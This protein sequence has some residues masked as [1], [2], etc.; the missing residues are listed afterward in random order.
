MNLI[1][2]MIPTYKTLQI[3]GTSQDIIIS[4]NQSSFNNSVKSRFE[5]Y[6]GSIKTE[7]N[8]DFESTC[9][10]AGT[11]QSEMNKSL[12][13]MEFPNARIENDEKIEIQMN[14]ATAQVKAVNSSWSLNGYKGATDGS[15]A[16]L[17]TGVN[18]SQ[19]FLNGKVIG[20]HNFVNLSGQPL[21][22]L[23]PPNHSNRNNLLAQTS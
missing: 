19:E 13:K 8:G 15:V 3:S 4:F 16:V 1:G 5:Y 22:R 7:W 23:H 2:K 9:G 18:S 17:D 20:W 6:G 10:F 14:Y 11:M 21:C 12:F